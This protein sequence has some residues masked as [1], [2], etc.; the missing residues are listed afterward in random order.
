MLDR[1]LAVIGAA[2]LGALVFF[3]AEQIW[4]SSECS[5]NPTEQ[6][7]T[8][9]A[10][11]KTLEISVPE[12]PDEKIASYTLWLAI[13]TGC[14]VG[15][16]ALQI[17]FLVKADETASKAAEA[18]LV[19]AESAKIQAN[20]MQKGAILARDEF[21]STHRPELIIRE[22]TWA[23]MEFEE[24]GEPRRSSIAFTIIN[25]GRS[26]CKI[27][28]SK[29]ELTTYSG[30]GQAVRTWGVNQLGPVT[31]DPG[32]F[33]T[34]SHPMV[35]PLEQEMMLLHQAD[36][37]REPTFFRGTIIYTDRANIRRRFAFTRRSGDGVPPQSHR[38]VPTHDPEEEY[39]D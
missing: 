2:L 20:E 7:R 31:F 9:S 19:A 38:F 33:R 27:I 24:N 22:V 8:K 34:F 16:S 17:R 36:R 32:Q 23:I 14:L 12:K 37:L 39:T 28:E 4:R 5:N 18:A 6:G 26:F 11:A 1:V 15:V 30:N 3:Y 10:K 29:T 25:K 13:L 21:L 35:S